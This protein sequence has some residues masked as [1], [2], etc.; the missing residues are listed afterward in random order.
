MSKQEQTDQPQT[1]AT[2]ELD[3]DEYTKV[4]R[5]ANLREIRLLNSNYSIKPEVTAALVDIDNVDLRFSGGFSV[6][7]FDEPQG[8]AVGK[9][10]WTA[11]VREGRKKCL[12]IKST[13]LLVYSGLAGCKSDHVEYFFAKVGRFATYP[14]FRSHFNHHVVESGLMMPPLPTLRERVD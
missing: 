10:E 2:F 4:S 13:Y 12:K 9:F 5:C 1:Q 14:Y 8:I 11:E 7:D 3:H 6:M